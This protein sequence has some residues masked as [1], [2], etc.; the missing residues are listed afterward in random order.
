MDLISNF[1]NGFSIKLSLMVVSDSKLSLLIW[2]HYSIMLVNEL[3]KNYDPK[4]PLN[5]YRKQYGNIY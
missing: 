2:V 3:Q 5:L 4:H 1:I